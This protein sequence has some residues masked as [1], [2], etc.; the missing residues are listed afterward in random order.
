MN[1]LTK[2]SRAFIDGAVGLGGSFRQ[3]YLLVVRQSTST[4]G[5]GSMSP[6]RCSPLRTQ[7]ARGLRSRNDA[8]VCYRRREG[9]QNMTRKLPTCRQNVHV[10]LWPN[11]LECAKC[12]GLN[13]PQLHRPQQKQVSILDDLVGEE[14]SLSTIRG[15]ARRSTLQVQDRPRQQQ[16]CSQDSHTFVNVSSIL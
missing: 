11:T 7:Q 10:L 8:Q 5:K 14:A 2:Q 9:C 12:Q 6:R 3:T 15:G 13:D 16:H 1:K 4:Q